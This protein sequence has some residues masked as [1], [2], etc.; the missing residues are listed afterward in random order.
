MAGRIGGLRQFVD[1]LIDLVGDQEVQA[2]HVVRGLARAA[3][4]D[5]DAVL[6]LVALPRLAHGEAG[7][8]GDQTDEQDRRGRHQDSR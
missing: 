8:Q 5:P 2:E 3:P 7:E 1:R 4:I 6:E